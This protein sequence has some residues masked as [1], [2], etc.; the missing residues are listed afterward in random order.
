[1]KLSVLIPSVP[2]RIDQAVRLYRKIMAQAGSNP[3]HAEVIMLLDNKL[4]T[5]GEKRQA[6][7][8]MARGTYVAFVDDDDDISDDYLDTI[9]P[10]LDGIVDVVCFDVDCTY[11]GQHAIVTSSVR[12]GNEDFT[13]DSIVHRKPCHVHAW[14]RE[15]AVQ[16]RFPAMNYGEDFA[17][18]GSLWG[19]VRKEVVIPAVL[20]YYQCGPWSETQ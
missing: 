3:D 10:A 19:L 9:I 16:S 7:L 12:F 20:Y 17:W 11:N 4:R 2:S 1:M 15:V 8:D 14:R 6:L 5:V 13:P 18:A